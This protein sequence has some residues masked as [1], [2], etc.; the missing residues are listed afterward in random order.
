MPT[1]AQRAYASDNLAAETANW[2]R[3]FMADREDRTFFVI[4]QSMPLFWLTH[5]VACTSIEALAE[6]WAEFAYHY[7]RGTFT[8]YYIVQ[9][10]A[11][12]NFETGELRAVPAAD[13]G[14]AVVLEPVRQLIL[15]PNY[16]IR[17]SRITSIDEDRLKVW[18]EQFAKDQIGLARAAE[19]HR[20][21]AEEKAFIAEW[22][23]K[24][25]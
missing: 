12:V 22:L 17:M 14:D 7:K 20:P 5:E 10:L 19:T 24:L 4:E 1:I 16:A 15:Q 23:Q 9:K 21:S 25:P 18:A 13:L 11:P 6:R 3:E 2:Q 8:D